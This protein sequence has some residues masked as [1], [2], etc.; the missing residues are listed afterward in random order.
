MR[1]VAKFGAVTLLVAAGFTASS[2][3]SA[4]AGSAVAIWSNVEVSGATP[5]QLELARWAVGRFKIAGLQAPVVEIRFHTDASGCDGHL[6]YAQAGRVDVCTVLANEMARRNLLHEMG[7]IWID[8]NVPEMR[9][10]RFL[11]LRGLSSWNSSTN[12]WQ[13]RGYEQAAETMAWALG[14]RILSPQIPD[15]HP[16]QLVAAFE[17]LTG[18]PLPHPRDV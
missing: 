3:R 11:D 18:A 7:H 17:L 15:N 2:L 14:D 10:E 12:P 4:G 13:V 16:A 6:G 8:Q 5:Q 1:T 9:R